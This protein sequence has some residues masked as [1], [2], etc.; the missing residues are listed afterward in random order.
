MMTRTGS[1][2]NLNLFL[3]RCP[4]QIRESRPK[5]TLVA[6][7]VASVANYDYIMDW[8]FQMDGLVRIKVLLVWLCLCLSLTTT[9]CF[10]YTAL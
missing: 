6:R 2:I 4:L 3:K 10:M 7:M 8:E 1:Q 9:I 5:V